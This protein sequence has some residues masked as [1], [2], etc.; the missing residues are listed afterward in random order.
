MID[1]C[2]S[3][4]NIRRR[5]KDDLGCYKRSGRLLKKVTVTGWQGILHRSYSRPR[6]RCALL[7]G[8]IY[9]HK[10]PN[11]SSP[12]PQRAANPHRLQLTNLVLRGNVVRWRKRT[13][14]FVGSAASLNA[15]EL[16]SKERSK[17]RRAP[18]V[19]STRKIPASPS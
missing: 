13:T 5:P 19:R 18:A 11:C 7:N 9:S 17:S 3:E 4:L 12:L 8:G 15:S 14:A 1:K 16:S 10:N 2:C 6:G